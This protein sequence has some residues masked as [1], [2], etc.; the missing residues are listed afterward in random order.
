M[1]PALS[2]PFPPLCALLSVSTCSLRRLN[3]L[4]AS[5]LSLPFLPVAT[6]LF[7][8]FEL[9]A[10][11]HHVPCH[12]PSTCF[13]LVSQPHHCANDAGRLLHS[14]TSLLLSLSHRAFFGCRTNR[15]LASFAYRGAF[16]LSFLLPVGGGLGPLLLSHACWGVRASCTY[17]SLVGFFLGFGGSYGWA[18]SRDGCPRALQDY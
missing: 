12:R 1:H 10:G 17:L 5:F 9:F 11:A 3:I 6:L 18:V 4:S 8:S 13:L 15:R 7:F 2:S 16:R 14:S